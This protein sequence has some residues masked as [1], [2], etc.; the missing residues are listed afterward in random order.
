MGQDQLS[1]RIL[2]S[3]SSGLIGRSLVTALTDEG[4][5]VIKLARSA[6]RS[7]RDTVFI[8]YENENYELSDFEGFDSVIH[9][10][11]ENIVSRW[12]ERKK[13]RIVKSRVDTTRLLADIFKKVSDPPGHFLCASAI[14]IY[15][16][17]GS[18]MADERS[19]LSGS[20]FLAG[21]ARDWE[22]AAGRA[23]ELGARV[24]NLRIGLVLDKRG[25][26]LSKMLLPF[27]LGLGGHIGSGE[28]IWSWISIDDIV[29]SIKFVLKN[30]K[31]EGP[32]NLVSP[33]PCTN[34]HFTKIL[35]EVLN[36]PAFFHLPGFIIRS[37]FGEM[38]E[39]VILSGVNVRPG[40]LLEN[41]YRF[42]DTDIKRTLIKLVK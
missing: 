11:G 4:H 7:S 12:T 22:A 20:G 25:G 17:A 36:R 13:R 31:I 5:E 9:L 37:I 38:A 32:V 19:E 16:P 8:D 6:S 42:I 15:S 34:A 41:G 33:N 23:R 14:G 39:E 18:V 40:K 2:I 24:V 1:M 3:G 26:A 28:Q 30:D 27:S 29:S 10:A 21:L 35:A